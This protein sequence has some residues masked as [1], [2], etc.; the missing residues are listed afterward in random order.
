[1]RI[2]VIGKHME[3]TDAIRQYAENKATKLLRHYDGVQQIDF[4]VEPEPHKKGFSCEVVADVEK[5]E[6]FISHAQHVDLYTAIDDA[7]NK[8]VRQLTDFKEKLKEG[9]H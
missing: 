1:M 9:K 4:R 8:T 6:D 3:V 7:V 2:N 5:H